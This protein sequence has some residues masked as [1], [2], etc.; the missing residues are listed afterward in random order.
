MPLLKLLFFVLLILNALA[1]AAGMGWLGPSAPRGEPERL[2]N[3]IN[4]QL[5]RLEALAD[6]APQPPPVAVE[7]VVE[8]PAATPPVPLTP[9][10]API[11]APPVQIPPPEAPAPQP[12]TPPSPDV[13]T[14]QET[15]MACSAIAG[16]SETL[17]TQI[18][19]LA[20]DTGAPVETSLT[21][22]D[23]ASGWW[24]RVPPAPNRQAADQRAQE[25]RQLGVSD[26]FVVREAGPEQHAISLGL[27]RT[28]AAA[29][30][31]LADL[32]R[33]RVTGA[34]ITA[35]TPANYRLEITAPS[36]VLQDIL[37]RLPGAA[38][39]A[40]RETCRQ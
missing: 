40:T 6:A 20:R 21:Q 16:L 1:L 22:T 37:N 11:P 32:Q 2:T 4:P 35:R 9:A 19:R 24:V 5:I 7:E 14:R 25:L 28:E 30:Q 34:E 36:D 15:P 31:H 26:L 18:E 38:T 29:R 8:A 39:M 33:L 10:P 27:F 23:A 13:A 3:Q 12:T 17:A